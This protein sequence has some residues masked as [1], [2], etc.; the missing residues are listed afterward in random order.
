M[1][2]DSF[3]FCLNCQAETRYH[4]KQKQ[5][6]SQCTV[7]GFPSLW[8]IQGELSEGKIAAYEKELTFMMNYSGPI[9]C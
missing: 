7:C 4:K 8:G 5:H 9:Y 3:R 1:C 2:K 6:H